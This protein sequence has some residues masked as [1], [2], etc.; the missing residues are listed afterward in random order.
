MARRLEVILPDIIDLDQPGFVKQR[1]TQDNIKC[2]LLVMQNIIKRGIEAV[3]LGLDME[4]AFDSVRWNFLYKVFEKCGFSK[5]FIKTIH[6]LYYQPMARIKINGNLSNFF[7]L[8][9]GC[10][11]GCAISPLLFAIY[12]EPLSQRIKENENIT[13]IRMEGG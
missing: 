11:Q 5:I 13:G 8:Q 7:I 6:L 4:K 2:T 12:L 1:Q 10:C 9:R 3:I